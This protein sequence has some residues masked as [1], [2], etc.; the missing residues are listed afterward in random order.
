MAMTFDIYKRGQGKYTRLGTA[1]AAAAI[2]GLGCLQLYKQLDATNLGLWVKTMV[3]AGLFVGLSLLIFW[4]MNK[5]SL[6]DFLVAAEGEMKKVSWSSRKEV[7]VSTFIVIVVVV[8]MA[9]LLGTTDL[10]FGL[11]FDWLLR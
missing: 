11:F 10:T 2:A 9:V 7:A 6:A 3:P 5:P 1:L 4:L 8:L